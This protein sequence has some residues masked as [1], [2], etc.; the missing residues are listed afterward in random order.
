MVCIVVPFSLIVLPFSLAGIVFGH[1]AFD[2]IKN[3]K[4]MKRLR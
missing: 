4:K 1:P 2:M 3:V